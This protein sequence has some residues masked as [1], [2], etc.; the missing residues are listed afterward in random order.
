[1][2]YC[3]NCQAY[4]AIPDMILCVDCDSEHETI[5]LLMTI[6]AENEGE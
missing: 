3:E 1:M 2:E 5:Q 6:I 4:R